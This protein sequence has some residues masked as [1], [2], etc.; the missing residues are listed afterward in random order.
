MARFVNS[1]FMQEEARQFLVEMT[2]VDLGGDERR[3][4]D[5]YESNKRGLGVRN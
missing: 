1:G 4:I 5:W 2:G 3:W